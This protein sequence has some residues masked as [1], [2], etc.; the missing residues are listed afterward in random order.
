MPI[1]IPGLNELI[2]GGL[3]VPSLILVA[4][5]VGAGKTT[6]CTQFLCQGASLGEP[7]LFFLAF[8]GSPEWASKLASTYDFV[9]KAHIGRE[10][11]YIELEIDKASGPAPLL[12]DIESKMA[13]FSPR[14]VVIDSLSGIGD[15]LKDDYRQFLHS[16][17][18][19]IKDQRAVAMV[20]GDSAHSA[21]YP[22][23]VAQ[24]ADGIILLQNA[25]VDNVRKRSIEVLK[26]SGTAHQ[27]G[28][29]AVDI[30]A[31]G[32]TVYPGL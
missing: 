31:K 9:N 20:T 15:L 13:N 12:E 16:L 26:M 11:S 28:K 18:G 3:P 7:C 17:S 6:L 22:V 25:E 2:K 32:L 19:I 10:I 23:E 30:S 8:S 24:V 14:R 1:G 29:H 5:D 27:L 4:G 21:P